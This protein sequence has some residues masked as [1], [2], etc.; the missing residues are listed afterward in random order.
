MCVCV[1]GGGG[2]VCACERERER[3]IH[4]H[5][6]SLC[7]CMC[8][9]SSHYRNVWTAVMHGQ[10]TYIGYAQYIPTTFNTLNTQHSQLASMSVSSFSA[11]N[12]QQSGPI[13]HYLGLT[14]RHV[15]TALDYMFV[16]V[17]AWAKNTFVDIAWIIL[18]IIHNNNKKHKK[19]RRAKA[20]T[21]HIHITYRSSLKSSP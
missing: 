2:G 9:I 17:A 20:Q 15:F 11:D 18:F 4:T 14:G 5:D 19:T 12:K 21:S 10:L 8:N 13:N 7:V 16:K 3:H 1:G 6:M